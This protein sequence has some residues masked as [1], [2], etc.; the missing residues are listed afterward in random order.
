MK[1]TNYQVWLIIILSIMYSC[2]YESDN[3]YY[4]DIEKPSEIY[5]GLD[6]A[7]VNPDEPIYIYDNTKLYYSLNTAGRKVLLVEASINGG[8]IHS[9]NDSFLMIDKNNLNKEEDNILN[10]KI[11][12]KTGN[13]SI[14]DIMNAEYYEGDFTYIL[15]V[16]ENDIQLA[17]KETQTDDGYLKLE[18]DK[19]DLPQL[20]IAEYEITYTDS[21]GDLQKI[22]QDGS[23]NYFIDKNY[24]YG[25]RS[26][27]IT[28]KFAGEKL[29]DK[30]NVY[31]MNYTPMTSDDITISFKD[32]EE[33]RISWKSNK[34]RC[35]YFVQYNRNVEIVAIA[36]FTAPEVYLSAPTFPTETG[37]YTV[38]IVSDD[39]TP[40]EITHQTRGFEKFFQYKAPESPLDMAVITWDLS[41]NLLWGRTGITIQ[42]GNPNTLST[43][44]SINSPYFQ[45]LSDV[46]ISPKTEKFLVFN[47]YN[48]DI[49]DNIVYVFSNK[50][51]L[52]NATPI[53][54][55]TPKKTSRYGKVS[56]IDDDMIFIESSSYAEPSNIIY[57]SLINIQTGN[58]IDH[59]EHSNTTSLDISTDRE[60]L[61]AFDKVTEKL[62]VYNISLSGLT[63]SQTIN[64]TN[65]KDGF[66]LFNPKNPN[67]VILASWIQNSFSVVELS[68]QITKT[69]NGEF[70][71]IDPFTGRIYCYNSSYDTNSLIDIYENGQWE[72]PIFQFKANKY[73]SLDVYNDFVICYGSYAQICI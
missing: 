42:L 10:V 29:S 61:I 17:V 8:D 73:G 38:L 71:T 2:E 7:G 49:T 72:K 3:E 1:L 28:M 68:T 21:R 54:V 65:T 20:E 53:E 55:V 4:K 23:I 12:I 19:I 66:C 56:L 67:Q 33:T 50:N 32:L 63:L 46:S 27:L 51:N 15:K 16:V 48:Y 36:P 69:I 45:N 6:L 60:K 43:L 62:Q 39:T 70:I 64:I 44:K 57:S 25:Y 31:N 9:F 35:Q 52:T 14:A 22:I 47:G 30:I 5:I 18:W 34:Y 13:G 26:Y 40:S 41:N 37:H 24:V 58:I 59:L 11:R